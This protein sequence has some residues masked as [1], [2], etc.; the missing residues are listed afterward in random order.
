[1]K[2]HYLGFIEKL[3]KLAEIIIEVMMKGLKEV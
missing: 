3:N 1:M 2:K